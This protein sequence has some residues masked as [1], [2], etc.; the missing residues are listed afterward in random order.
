MKRGAIVMVLVTAAAFWPI[1]AASQ[2][3]PRMPRICFIELSRDSG[4]RF[5][6]M[7]E[8]LHELG[9]VD[10]QTI[11]ID[12]RSA[13][14]RPERYPEL[15]R[16]CIERKP[17][18]IIVQTTPAAQAAKQE[19]ST[20][21]IVMVNLGDPVAVGLVDNLARPGGNVT[22]TTYMAPD[23]AAKRLELLKEAAPGLSR[24][25]LL[26]YPLD[27][28]DAP[29]MKEME[30]AAGV[31][32]VTLHKREIRSA[33][34]IPAAFDSAATARSEAL[35]MPAVSLFFVQRAQILEQ[36]DRARMPGSY[37]W[38]EYAEGGGLIY[39]GQRIDD[40]SRRTAF[41]VDRILKGAK[42]ADIPIERAT[43]FELVVNLKTARALGLTIPVSLLG[44]ADEVIE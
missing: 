30:R 31:L 13:E 23:L 15:V 29:Q 3:S 38:R 7:F 17:D 2:A 4:E 20:I 37:P 43:R 16:G 22:G 25:L 35:I 40:V 24:F 8:T 32:G 34:D 21:P 44:R 41:I 28:V 39:Y 5:R 18:V 1:A 12:R 6:A 26:S 19:T 33:A 10:G 9:R 27:P 11:V 36:A 42:P 14:N